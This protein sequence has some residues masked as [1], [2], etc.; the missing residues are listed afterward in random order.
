MLPICFNQRFRKHR[1]LGFLRQTTGVLS[2]IIASAVGASEYVGADIGI[3]RPG[4]PLPGAPA[5]DFL[6]Q[7]LEQNPVRLSGFRGKPVV[8]NFFASWCSPCLQELPII[9]A[10]YLR[11]TNGEFIVLGV[12]FQDSR[13]AIEELANDAGLTFPIVI[14]GDNSV[15]QA[16]RVIGPPYTFFID[17]SGIV[18]EVVSGAM[19]QE[20]LQHN[21]D[22][23][24]KTG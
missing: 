24:L 14:D 3:T 18:V 7:D 2:I 10:A 12:S 4:V 5:P 16:Y 8:L 23:L 15:G 17:A 19:E 6:L 9:Q 22:I 11:A 1:A 13:W 21:L 20:T